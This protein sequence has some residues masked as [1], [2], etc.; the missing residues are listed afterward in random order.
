MQTTT[1][2]LSILA[3]GLIGL[4]VGFTTPEARPIAPVPLDQ[5]SQSEVVINLSNPTTH[6]KF[7]VPDL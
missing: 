6:P 1:T 5:R 2:R 3:F 4:S 7:G